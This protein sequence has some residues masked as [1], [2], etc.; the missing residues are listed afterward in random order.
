MRGKVRLY[1]ATT[2]NNA[3]LVNIITSSHAKLIEFTH[4]DYHLGE[5][6]SPKAVV[7]L[8]CL[9]PSLAL[10]T[11]LEPDSMGTKLD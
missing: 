5:D 7:E 6:P 11:T 3:Q 1:F 10:D 8:G 2:V 4:I 9:I